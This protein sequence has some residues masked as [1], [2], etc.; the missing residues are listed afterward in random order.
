VA[1]AAA[2]AAFVVVEV[3]DLLQ[4][5][6]ALKRWKMLLPCWCCCA[7]VRGGADERVCVAGAGAARGADWWSECGIAWE[8]LGLVSVVV[9]QLQSEDQRRLRMLPLLLLESGAA[10]AAGR[11]S[12]DWDA[13]SALVRALGLPPA[14]AAAAAAWPCL[15][16]RMSGQ[17][18]P[19]LHQ[20]LRCPDHCLP[21]DPAACPMWQCRCCR[22]SVCCQY[23][24][25][26]FHLCC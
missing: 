7:G 15:L 25:Y 2:A 19:A 22:C 14:A 11:S 1:A 23:H 3:V 10:M 20:S 9:V 16:H 12:E 5:R 24:S 13:L 4:V 17:A 8:W 26:C 18:W 6:Q 21:L